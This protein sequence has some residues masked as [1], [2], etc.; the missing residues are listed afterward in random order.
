MPSSCCFICWCVHL[1]DCHLFVLRVK[2][3]LYHS[4]VDRSQLISAFFALWLIMMATSPCRWSY[5]HDPFSTLQS[6][7]SHTF[8]PALT[9]SKNLN[10]VYLHFP[11]YLCHSWCFCQRSYI[12][13]PNDGLLFW[14]HYRSCR[15]LSFSTGL[16]QSRHVSIRSSS[17]N[18]VIFQ[19]SVCGFC[20]NMFYGVGVLTLRPTPNLEDQWGSPRVAN[21]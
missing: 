12:P 13:K 15:L 19:Y 16:A 21:V 7:R 8:P 17:P 5:I 4:L 9:N 6:H 11:C 10:P 1:E 3:C 14:G 2:S 18:V 20:N